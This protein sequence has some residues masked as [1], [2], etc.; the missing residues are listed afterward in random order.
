[1]REVSARFEATI[2]NCESVRTFVRQCTQQTALSDEQRHNLLIAV[3]EHFVNLVEHAFKGQTGAVV[4]V[5]CRQDE[6]QV[7]VKIIDASAGFDPRNFVI[8][9]VEGVPVDDLTPGGFGN[10]FISELMDDVDYIHQPYKENTLILTV[11]TSQQPTH[12][13]IAT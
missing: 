4:T 7:Q 12:Q 13:N 1:M 8:P 11:Y 6:K 2:A 3:D 10:Y 9:D 5:V